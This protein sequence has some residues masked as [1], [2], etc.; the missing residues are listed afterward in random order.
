MKKL[1]ENKEINAL[2][3]AVIGMAGRFPGAVNLDE[4]WKNLK[5]GRETISH[6]S[7]EE[8][9]AAGISRELLE[10]KSYIRAKGIIED[11]DCFDAEFFYEH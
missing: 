11:I 2:D 7:R 10:N 9:E 3:I 8:L 4:F 5:E 1:P 6:F